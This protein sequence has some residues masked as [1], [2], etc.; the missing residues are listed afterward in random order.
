MSGAGAFSEPQN[1]ELWRTIFVDG[2][3]KLRSFQKF[4]SILPSPPRCKM[5]FAPFCGIGSLWM[6][7]RGKGPS[8]R[9]PRYC[10]ACDKFLRAFPGGAEIDLSMVFVDVRGSVPLAEQLKPAEYSRYMAG[11]F[12]SATQALINTDGFVI[13][14][15]GDC[16]VGVYPPGFSGSDHAK[17]AIEA[18][19]QLVGDIQ[20]KTPECAVLPIGVG[21]HW[22]TVYI[23]TMSGAEGGMQDIGIFGDNAN[24]AARLS[25]AAGPGEALISDALCIVSG[26]PTDRLEARQL[27]LKGRSAACTAYV[28][29]APAQ[30]QAA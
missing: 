7:L 15:R 28:I 23:G 3:P 8:S 12:Q 4:H 21:A 29:S 11:F 30:G 14:F 10:S 1:E 13:D 24:I 9:N 6:R 20:P 18:A 25:Q 16:V 26:L 22:G 27:E 2:H 17:K 19:H 5:C